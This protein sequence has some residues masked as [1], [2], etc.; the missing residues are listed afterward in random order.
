MNDKTRESYRCLPVHARIKP[1]QR[2][3]TSAKDGDGF[4]ME[5]RYG[6]A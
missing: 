2:P 6:N 3:I 5:G 4:S 1:V